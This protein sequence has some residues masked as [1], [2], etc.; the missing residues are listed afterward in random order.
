M[1][2]ALHGAATT[3]SGAVLG[4]ISDTI[5]ALFTNTDTS[6]EPPRNAP[7]AGTIQQT[8]PAASPSRSPTLRAS[9][10]SAAPISLSS[11]SSWSTHRTSFI[12]PYEHNSPSPENMNTHVDNSHASLSEPIFRIDDAVNDALFLFLGDILRLD[13]ECVVH[14]TT[15]RL[16]DHS[17]RLSNRIAVVGGADLIRECALIADSDGCNTGDAV[18]TRAYNMNAKYI[19]H[20]VAPRYTDKFAIA[21]EHALH[22]CYSKTLE[23][24]HDQHIRSIAFPVIALPK[25]GFPVVNA[26]HIALRTIRR[27][28]E[29]FRPEQHH[30]NIAIATS[31]AAEYALYTYLLPLY[32]PRNEVEL[33]RQLNQLPANILETNEFGEHIIAERALP[34]TSIQPL[35]SPVS[36]IA[37]PSP[38]E[39]DD[40]SFC[41][42]QDDPDTRK[43]KF[44]QSLP[45]EERA[46]R[47]RDRKYYTLI[48]DAQYEDVT[49]LTAQRAIFIPHQRDHNGDPV[50]VVVANRLHPHNTTV[51]QLTAF[52]ALTF[53]SL[54]SLGRQYSIVYCHTNAS[55]D[56]IVSYAL[57]SKLHA[58]LAERFGPPRLKRILIVHPTMMIHSL[59]WFLSPF[60]TATT[61]KLLRTVE[62]LA[63]AV[64]FV[65]PNQLELPR[66]II[67]YDVAMYSGHRP[68]R[69]DE[70]NAAL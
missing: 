60:M 48:R 2:L 20:T 59:L 64:D 44:E 33:Y 4:G 11:L 22:C 7:D 31:T 12:S 13:V 65:D 15:E 9:Y 6:A 55:W 5:T 19:I 43:L 41:N 66:D 58:A 18:M 21:A 47:E 62:R 14:S 30:V 52:I 70:E 1:L 27:F 38:Y 67:E 25:K 53:H 56:N 49:A 28:L 3:S 69:D 10:S 37:L 8:S 63:D 57:C 36:M 45:P 51:N 24:M 54:L 61:M 40:A 17:T 39:M 23:I 46:K 50:V 26:V 42:M 35:S 29:R 32:F 16:I 34:R 68:S